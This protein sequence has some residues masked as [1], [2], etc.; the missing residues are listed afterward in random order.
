MYSQA[1]QRRTLPVILHYEIIEGNSRYDLEMKQF[2][3][4]EDATE[5]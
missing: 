1:N 3:T 2:N 4:T 5:E